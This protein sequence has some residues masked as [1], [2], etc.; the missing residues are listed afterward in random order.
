[1]NFYVKELKQIEFLEV[2]G[3][4]ECVIFK[5]ANKYRYEIILRSTKVNVLLNAL[6]NI[7]SNIATIDMDVIT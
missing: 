4:K 2:V 7:S 3:F 1:M 5:I 6:H